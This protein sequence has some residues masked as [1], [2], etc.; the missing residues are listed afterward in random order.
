MLRI[1]DLKGPVQIRPVFKINLNHGEYGAAN[2][3]F[4]TTVGNFMLE[5]L[6]RLSDTF[7]ET[8]PEAVAFFHKL[9]WLSDFEFTHSAANRPVINITSNMQV[10]K[11]DG[12]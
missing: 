11:E 12:H 3:L 6:Q 8:K 5:F 4:S 2:A 1:T 7:L 9:G 10:R